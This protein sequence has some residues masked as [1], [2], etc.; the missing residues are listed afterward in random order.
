[1]TSKI[2]AMARLRCRLASAGFL[3]WDSIRFMHATYQARNG[4][5]TANP[6]RHFADPAPEPITRRVRQKTMKGKLS[7][8]TA[9]ALIAVACGTEN[10]GDNPTTTV[11]PGRTT[12]TTMPPNNLF[13]G[14]PNRLVLQ[15]TEQGGYAPVEL[16]VNRLPRFSVYA[17]GTLLAPAPVPAVYPGP[18]VMP[19]Q[20]ISL[21]EEN[22][23]ALSEKIEEMGLPAIDREIDDSLADLVADATTV[24]A[25]FVDGNGSEHIYGAYALFLDADEPVSDTT[26]HLGELF[27]LLDSFL[28]SP[29]SQLFE[30]DRIQLW[31]NDA[32]DVDPDFK[33]TLPWPLAVTPE[34]FEPEG[35]FDFGC[36]VLAGDAAQ[37]AISALNA[38]S[39][40]TLWDYEGTELQLIV[41][42]LLPDEPGCIP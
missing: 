5:R 32:P 23:F 31:V 27:K 18:I 6:T 3:R 2:A 20:S 34:D 9:L 33:H 7:I 15:I 16:I 17:D 25:T 21:S 4:A 30:P 12:T 19:L 26:R 35:E 42:I 1:M 38:A 39:N 10:L 29:G 22:L 41:R 11:D 8:M 40:A 36:H 14:D 37:A 13:T 28:A 24:I